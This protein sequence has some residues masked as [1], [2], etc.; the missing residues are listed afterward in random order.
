MYFTS[1]KNYIQNDVKPTLVI[2]VCQT[3]SIKEDDKKLELI[4]Q[5]YLGTEYITNDEI[6][7]QIAKQYYEILMMKI[8]KGV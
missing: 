5:N 3:I 2:G 1:I 8:R 7:N 4:P 6:S